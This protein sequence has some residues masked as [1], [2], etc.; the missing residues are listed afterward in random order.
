MT[1]AYQNSDNCKLELKFAK[2]TGIPIVPIMLASNEWRATGWLGI[3]T[4]GSLWT[5]LA[6]DDDFSHNMTNIIGQIQLAVP[7]MVEESVATL[8]H[9]RQP[10]IADAVV[11]SLEAEDEIKLSLREMRAELERLRT[12]SLASSATPMMFRSADSSFARPCFLPAAVP[13][14]PPEIVVSPA[15][16]QLVETLVSPDTTMKVGF[17]G[18]GGAT[19]YPVTH[20]RIMD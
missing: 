3:L 15:M 1:E 20:T 9:G 8:N 10:S 12:E 5:P 17:H 2:Q 18:M 4:A 19:F 6:L 16:Q 14:L 13:E 11:D 7:A